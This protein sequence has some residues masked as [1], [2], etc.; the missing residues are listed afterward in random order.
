MKLFISILMVGCL[1]GAPAFAQDEGE[2]EPVA[3]PATETVEE[4]KPEK[5]DRGVVWTILLYIPNRIF[6]L[7]DIVRARVRVAP[8]LQVNARATQALA[9]GAG[10]YTGVFAGIPGPRG[11]RKIALPVGFESEA[12]AQVSAVRAG[13]GP[14]YGLLEVGAGFQAVFLGL[15]IGVDPGEALDF[16]TSIFLW[17]FREDDL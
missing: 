2:A 4:A 9:V 14:Y 3:E 16:V 11:G 12:G 8:G 15:D 13:S 7:T 1:V 17:D 10:A 6:D 5:K